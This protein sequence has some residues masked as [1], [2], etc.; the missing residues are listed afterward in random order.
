MSTFHIIWLSTLFVSV[1]MVIGPTTYHQWRYNSLAA[2][3]S[4][5][6]LRRVA[7]WSYWITLLGLWLG[8]LWILSIFIN[9]FMKGK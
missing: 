8:T 1:V 4:W 6:H 7:P 5:K 3:S 2:F 9:L